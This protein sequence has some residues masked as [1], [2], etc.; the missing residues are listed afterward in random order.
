MNFIHFNTKL[1]SLSQHEFYFTIFIYDEFWYLQKVGKL[2]RFYE[3]F[4]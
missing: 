1:V 4:F 2:T 3:D